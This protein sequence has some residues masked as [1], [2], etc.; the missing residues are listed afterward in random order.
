MDRIKS[1]QVKRDNIGCLGNILS[2]YERTKDVMEMFKVQEDA[3]N[4]LSSFVFAIIVIVRNA[5][6][7]IALAIIALAIIARGHEDRRSSFLL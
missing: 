1:D 3:S 7:G 4:A 6:V 5:L 2:R